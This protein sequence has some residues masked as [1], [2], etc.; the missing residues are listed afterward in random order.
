MARSKSSQSWLKTHFSDPFVQQAWQDGLRSRAAYK[1][2]EIERRDQLFKA[3]Q[4]VI[5]LG[6]APGGWSQVAARLV[7]E[8]GLVMALDC[9][10]MPAIAGVEFIQGD[11]TLPETELILINRLLKCPADLVLSDM[12]PNLTGMKA[13]DQPRALYLN[14]LALDF[15]QKVLRTGGSLLLKVFQGAGTETFKRQLEQS[16]SKVVV[17]K[18]KASR[19]SSREIYFLAKGYTKRVDEDEKVD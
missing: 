6:A 18:P 14:K 17:R 4:C 13:V 11:F 10:P 12:A 16:F 8:T 19:A 3:G 7:T 9:L 2:L 5:D 1:L 15:A